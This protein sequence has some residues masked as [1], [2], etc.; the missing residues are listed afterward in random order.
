MAF[1]PPIRKLVLTTHVIASVG[2]LGAVAAFLV[3]AL[4]ALR[5]PDRALVRAI[6][7]AMEPLGRQ[8]VVPLSMASLGTGLVQSVGTRWGLLRHY[9][10]VLKLAI[11]L[12]ATVVLFLY[13]PTLGALAA[14]ARDGSPVADVRSTSPVLHSTAALV[15]L[16][17][18]TVLSVY[19]PPGMTKFGQRKQH[20][21]LRNIP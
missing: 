13:L 6:Y 5:T 2:W 7:I 16:A 20:E 10:V 21:N 3:L 19:K 12:I 17:G 1:P 11:N 15:L 8:V 4:V 14:K 9:W 18:A